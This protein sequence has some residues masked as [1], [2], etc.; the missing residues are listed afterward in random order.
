MGDTIKTFTDE[1]EKC[2]SKN[3]KSVEKS[4]LDS[5]APEAMGM[6]PLEFKQLKKEDQKLNKM[7]K[8]A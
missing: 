4:D 7:A 3:D 6:T 2:L 8:Q 1:L 5:S